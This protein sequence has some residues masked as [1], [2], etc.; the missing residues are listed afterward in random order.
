MCEQTRIPVVF[1]NRQEKTK[2][3]KAEKSKIKLIGTKKA[4]LDE[5]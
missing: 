1:H 5:M 4:Q 3:N 2:Q